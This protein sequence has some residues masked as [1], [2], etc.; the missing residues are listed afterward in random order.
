MHAQVADNQIVEYPIYSL[1]ARL[2][3]VSLP[4]DLTDDALLPEGFAYV[5]PSNIPTYDATTHDLVEAPPVLI[6]GHWY[7]QY[8]VVDLPPEDVE[9]RQLAAAEAVNAQRRNAYQTESDPVFFKW[10]RGEATKED[11]LAKVQD[12]R[13]RFTAP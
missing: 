1:H 5:R 2:P 11:W 12:I 3:N 9:A 7:R 6:D 8:Q 4:S 10:Q 13:E